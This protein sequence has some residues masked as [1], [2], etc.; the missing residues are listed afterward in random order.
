MTTP[1]KSIHHSAYRCR[2]AEETRAFYEDMLGLPLAAVV[3]EE[4]EPGSGRPN[5]FVHLFFRLGDGNFIA[6]FDAPGTVKEGDFTL[7]HGFDRHV[8]FEAESEEKLLAWR[9]QLNA[10]GVPCFGPIDHG[11]V[12]SVYFADPNGLPLEIAVRAAAHDA[13]LADDAK[14]AHAIINAW[15]ARKA[16]EQAA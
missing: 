12:K 2:D 10:G 11:F 13:I 8:A 5:P 6:F 3:Q 7:A 9:D 4:K 14:T 16:A 1:L 15:T